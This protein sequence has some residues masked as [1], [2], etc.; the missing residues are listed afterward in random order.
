MEELQAA[1]AEKEAEPETGGS[2]EQLI[3]AYNA[4]RGENLEAALG[5]LNEVDTQQISEGAM[6]LYREV[7]RAVHAEE[8]KGWYDAG[9]TA[10]NA[11]NWA[12]AVE[13]LQRVV[14]MEEMYQ[15]GY[16]IYYLARA[17]ESSEDTEKAVPLFRKFAEAY[18]GTV[19]ANYCNQALTRLGQPAVEQQQSNQPQQ[20]QEPQGPQENQ[21]QDPQPP[22]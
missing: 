2:Y 5:A 7:Y 12:E 22:A 4:F 16:A 18:P 6:S 21:P 3:E 8:L 11:G 9:E 1:L 10:Y 13:N 19:R 20:P 17:Y 14:D 15:D